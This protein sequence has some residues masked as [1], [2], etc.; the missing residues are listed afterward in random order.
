MIFINYDN[1]GS[2]SYRREIEEIL[3]KRLQAMIVKDIVLLE[4]NILHK[5]TIKRRP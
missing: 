3:Y 1:Y 4:Q 2:H 5:V